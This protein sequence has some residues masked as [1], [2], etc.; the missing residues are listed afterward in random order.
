[1]FEVDV[2]AQN[3]QQKAIPEGLLL[4]LQEDKAG[5]VC[6]KTTAMYTDLQ[7]LSSLS[8]NQVTV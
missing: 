6:Y 3:Q 4:I 2:N 7:L 5:M 1:M 8:F